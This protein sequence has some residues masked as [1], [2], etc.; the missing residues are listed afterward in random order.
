[1]MRR[2]SL[3][4]LLCYAASAAVAGNGDAR[5]AAGGAQAW[6][7][8]QRSGAQAGSDKPI[9]GEVA[10]RIFDRYLESFEQPI[11]ETFQR[12]RGFTVDDN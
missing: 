9:S 6:L 3:V 10:A 4:L 7:E 11:P 1:M 12:S 2:I 5:S 8:L